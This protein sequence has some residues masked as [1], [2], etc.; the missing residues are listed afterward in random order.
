MRQNKLGQEEGG[1]ALVRY[2]LGVIR[3]H[4]QFVSQM[5]ADDA[6]DAAKEGGSGSRAD[7]V[8]V[9]KGDDAE[10]RARTAAESIGLDPDKAVVKAADGTFEI[11]IG[12]KDKDGGISSVKMGEYNSNARRRLAARGEIDGSVDPN[13]D[14]GF[15]QWARSNQFGEGPE[16]EQR[17]QDMLAFEEEMESSVA[18]AMSLINDGATYVDSKGQEKSQ[19]PEAVLA[20]IG[21]IIKQALP[22]S[23]SLGSRTQNNQELAELFY[24]GDTDFSDAATRAKAAESIGRQI[25][26][27]KVMDAVQECPPSGPCPA[28]DWIMRN[29]MMTGGNATDITQLQT[30][31]SEGR[32]YAMNHNGIFN[33]MNANQDAVEFTARPGDSSIGIT[34][35][36]LKI[37]LGF[38]RTD[39]ASGPETRTVV[40]MPKGTVQDP[41][42]SRELN[43]APM[44]T[45]MTEGGDE[46]QEAPQEESTLYSFIRSQM[47][48]FEEF[49]NSPK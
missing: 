45:L 36:G 27:Q 32:S 1:A 10:A 11:G 12:Q 15:D 48:L 31:Y 24:K 16:A 14:E 39:S 46:E 35:N 29:A 21:K 5:G 26:V 25:R 8:L 43:G 18:T 22:F 47:E 7:T 28:K 38:E 2:T 9:Y 30:S 44:D 6:R 4:Q 33:E 34:V 3:Q 41:R 49:L 40:N 37:S 13:F 42:I 19:S 20:S 23:A 17:F